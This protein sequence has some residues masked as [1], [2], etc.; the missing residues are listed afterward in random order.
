M[1]LRNY[2]VSDRDQCL[3]LLDSNVPRFFAPEERREF[4]AFLDALPGRYFVMQS[5]DDLIACGGYAPKEM[6]CVALC[7]G[8]VRRDHHARG[9]GRR[10][11]EYR[12]DHIRRDGSVVRV[13]INTSQHTSGFYQRFGFVA[14]QII[15][16]GYA[17]G[18]DRWEMSLSL[19]GHRQK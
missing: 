12:L 3:A 18:L 8:M 16:D 9:I 2:E 11:L 14:D 1:S 13:T 6:G 17:A 5:G 19:A 4:A 15:P 7:W 10:L